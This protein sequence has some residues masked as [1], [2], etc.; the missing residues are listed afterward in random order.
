MHISVQGFL[1]MGLLLILV[2]WVE[3]GQFKLS[4]DIFQLEFELRELC[5]PSAS[6]FTENNDFFHEIFLVMNSREE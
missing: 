1:H 2:I 3:R 4:F 6:F 5:V